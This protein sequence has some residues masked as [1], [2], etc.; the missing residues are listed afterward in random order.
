MT[1]F[2]V[3]TL[4]DED[5]GTIDPND[6]D[7][8]LR[9]AIR[10]SVASFDSDTITF[11][12]DL[13]GGTLALTLGQLD[14]TAPITTRALTIDG[15]LND[16]RSPDITIDAQGQSR[17]INVDPTPS[18]GVQTLGSPVTLDGLVVTGGKESQ[19]GGIR[20]E[21]T[22][23]TLVNSIVRNNEA[24]GQ[25]GLVPTGAAGGIGINNTFGGPEVTGNVIM[26]STISDNTAG[27]FGGG[28]V[29]RRAFVTVVDS[30]V[31]GNSAESGGGGIFGFD[32]RSLN[33]VN[34]TISGNSATGDD[35]QG[36][37]ISTDS[38]AILDNVTIS[39]N[40]VKDAEGGGIKASSL[41]LRNSIV[42]GNA[43][44]TSIDDVGGTIGISNGAN[45]FSEANIAGAV[46]GDQQGVD[47][48]RVFDNTVGIGSTGVFAGVLADNGGPTQTIALEPTGLAVDV[49]GEVTLEQPGPNRRFEAP[50]QP[51]DDVLLEFDQ[52]GPDFNRIVDLPGVGSTID[53]GAFEV[54]ELPPPPALFTPG[55]DVRDLNGFDLTKFANSTNALAGDDTATLSE[56]QNLGVIFRA[57]SGDDVVIGSAQRDVVRG[58]ADDDRLRG[59]GGS[60]DLFG[61][62][63]DDSLSGRAGADL[64]SG[65]PGTDDLH[66]GSGRDTLR[67]GGGPDVLD[68]AGGNDRFD[69]NSTTAS[70]PDF[71]DLIDGFDDVGAAA[72]DVIDLAT[73]DANERTGGNDAFDFIGTDAFTDRGQLRVFNQAGDTVIVGNTKGGLA[74][75]FA[76]VVDDGDTAAA[77][78]RAADFVL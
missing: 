68:G 49:G 51:T 54:Q 48:A 24:V 29:F 7:L 21:S 65:G 19:D 3:Q 50:G 41:T 26:D 13:A 55:D 20:V 12:N 27:S 71:R 18:A 66:G 4:N 64:L 74:G 8:S 60:D 39:G 15:N 35:A 53:I 17:V 9:E 72:G 42:A 37:G 11:R 10:L 33:L 5:D 52:R 23:F 22:P 25:P 73:I 43:S 59:R 14:V 47:P 56:A 78:W 44:G 1:T 16:D 31:S 32:A 75:D 38:T 57:G 28:L 63:D 67:G 30:T 69:F 34:S 58:G 70:L 77:A 6:S 45:I 61:E 76:I 40:S 2:T 62:R 46:A 36:G